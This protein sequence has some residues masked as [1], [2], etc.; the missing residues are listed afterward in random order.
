M[1]IGHFVEG[2]QQ[3]IHHHQTHE[4]VDWGERQRH[5]GHRRSFVQQHN[6]LIF[7][8]KRKSTDETD[9]SLVWN[10]T[11]N[12]FSALFSIDQIDQAHY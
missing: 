2:A 10:E 8:C 4:Q 11:T 7:F 9:F 6:V 5:G 1:Q 3:E 12:L